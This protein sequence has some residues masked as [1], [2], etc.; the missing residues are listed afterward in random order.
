MGAAIRSSSINANP[1]VPTDQAKGDERDPE[2]EATF[3]GDR[4]ANPR[5]YKTLCW[6]ETARE[7][8]G[9]VSGISEEEA[10]TAAGYAGM[11]EAKTDKLPI[12]W[13]RKRLEDH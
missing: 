1:P 10:Q 6:L 2:K 13:S 12:T 7:R 9:D 5:L 8:G 3:K 4:P 11:P